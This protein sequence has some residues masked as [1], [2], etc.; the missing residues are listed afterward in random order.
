MSTIA[1]LTKPQIL[2][3]YRQYIRTAK[4]FTSYNF[5]EYFLRKARRDFRLYKDQIK[6]EEDALAKFNMIR[7][8][9]AILKRQ[10]I[11][12]EMYTFDKLVVEPIK[13]P[14]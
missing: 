13:T 6:T 10:S 4:D 1:A 12:S 14:K 7:E 5:R 8:E 2:N 9:L 3:L 11:I